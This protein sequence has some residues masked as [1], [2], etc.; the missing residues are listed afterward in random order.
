MEAFAEDFAYYVLD[1]A[2]FRAIRPKTYA[3][4]VKSFPKAPAPK[5]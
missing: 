4:F 5:P 1:E 3:F 2:T